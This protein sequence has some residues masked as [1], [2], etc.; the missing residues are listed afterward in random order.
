MFEFDTDAEFVQGL[1]DADEQVWEQ[2]YKAFLHPLK[3]YLAAR[4]DAL[5]PAEVD[6]VWSHVIETVFTR[7]DTLNDPGALGCW[8]WTIARNAAVDWFRDRDR[9]SEVSIDDVSERVDSFFAAPPLS[10]D[11]SLAQAL[12]RI[13]PE[14]Q[15]VLLA[16]VAGD[17]P[18]G[19]I[20]YLTGLVPQQQRGVLGAVRR[21]FEGASRVV[22]GD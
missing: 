2:F 20:Y 12:S 10:P 17:L 3:G 8:L 6:D 4:Y 16:G 18:E 1:R 14:Q 11:P 9:R 7:I 19:V 21:R 13:P 5:S 15:T 22:G